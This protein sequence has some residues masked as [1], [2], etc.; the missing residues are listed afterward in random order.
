M[1]STIKSAILWIIASVMTLGAAVY[2]KRTGPT[3]P[4][5]GEKMVGDQKI[6]YHLI[7][8]YNTGSQ[9]V[10]K[11]VVPDTAVKGEVTFR[12]FKSYDKW[13]TEPMFRSGDTLMALLPGLPAAGKVMYQVAMAKGGAK[14]L[15][16]DNPAVLRYKGAVPWFILI[17][18]I[19]FIFFAMLL[20]ARAGLEAIAKGRLTYVYTWFTVVFLAIGGLMLGPI[21]QKYAFDAYWTGWPFGSVRRCWVR[22]TVPRA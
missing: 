7:R 19:F 8:T 12:R 11:I 5:S 3:Y 1:N 9:A 13:T 2:Q 22:Q 6:Y 16:N 15:L 18:H 20:S 4:V 17:P 14:V 21:V 10:V